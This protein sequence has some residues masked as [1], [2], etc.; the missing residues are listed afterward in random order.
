M[1]ITCTSHVYQMYIKCTSHVY[2]MYIKCTSHVYQMY[3]KCTSHVY[4]SIKEF[5]HSEIQPMELATEPRDTAEH[6]FRD[7]SQPS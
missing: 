1:Y 4:P 7:C 3:I 2:H 5:N 6:V